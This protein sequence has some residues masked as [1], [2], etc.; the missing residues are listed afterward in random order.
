MANALTR[1]IQAQVCSQNSN[2]RILLAISLQYTLS[3]DLGS[4]PSLPTFSRGDGSMVKRGTFRTNDWY[5]PR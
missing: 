1:L 4:N 2:N 3:Q 5:L